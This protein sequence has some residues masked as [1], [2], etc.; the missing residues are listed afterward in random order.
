MYDPYE[1]QKN[2]LTLKKLKGLEPNTIFASGRGKIEHP[3]FNDAKNIDENNETEVNWVA[4]RGIIHDWNIYHSLDANLEP[5]EYFDGDTHLSATNERISDYGAKLYS[6]SK[7]REFVK[8]DD[9]AFDMY[10]L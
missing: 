5:T 2:M 9:E 8:C 7:I 10:R 3:W 4:V 6:K 1:E